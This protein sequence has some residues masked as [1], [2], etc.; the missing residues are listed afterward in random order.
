[1]TLRAVRSSADSS[2]HNMGTLF[3][4]AT[5]IGNLDDITLRA[6]NTLAS[7]DVIFAEDT[8]TTRVLC[9]RHAIKTPLVAFHQHSSAHAFRKVAEALRGGQRVALVSDAGTPGI[10]DPGGM[11]IAFIREAVPDAHIVPIPGANAAVAALSVSGFPADRFV[12]LGFPPHKK[13][14]QTFFRSL[15]EMHDTLVL[16]ESKHR[17]FKTLEALRDVSRIGERQLLVARELTKQFE[18]IVRGTIEEVIREFSRGDPRGE[19]VVVIAPEKRSVRKNK[20]SEEDPTEEDA[21]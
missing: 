14:R 21:E 10:N 11:L 19:F 7:A 6:I 16:Y 20:E 15:A 4:V 13:G 12:Y 3:I 1:M 18:T 5:P 2:R 9:E 8:R 17:I